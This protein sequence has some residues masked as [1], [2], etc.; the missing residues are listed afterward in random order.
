M[1]QQKI[2]LPPPSDWQDFQ[3]V[4]KQLAEIK[5]DSSKVSEYGRQGQI[6]HGIDIYAED[7]LQKRIG[8]QCK[9]CKGVLKPSIVEVDADK[10]TKFPGGLDLFIL[11]TTSRRDKKI[12][13]KVIAMNTSRKYSFTIRV[14]S[15]DDIV[16]DLNRTGQVLN[17]CYEAYR[18][19]FQQD[20]EQ[21]HF[22]CLRLAFDRPAYKD[23]F[24]FERSYD[25]FGEALA[26][27]K[28]LFRTGFAYDRLTKSLISQTV[29]LDRLPDGKYKSFVQS[30]EKKLEG[31]YRIFLR[32]RSRL[33]SDPV[34]AN[35]RAGQYNIERRKLIENL[36]ERLV[37]FHLSP[38]DLG[39]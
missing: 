21:H 3:A 2:Y 35:E 28:S 38:I 4:V 24:A 27:T 15:W 37:Q 30:L 11:A 19:A 5:F 7:F 25:E 9:E 31:L 32:D 13:D 33:N 29:P 10:A 22:Q 26:S 14:E 12:Q 16:D 34:Y 18:A 20:D 23:N 8:I 39:Y 36:N 1:G 6:Q 17:D